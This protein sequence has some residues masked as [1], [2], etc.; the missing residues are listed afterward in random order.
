MS[1]SDIE[2]VQRENV[3]GKVL[4]SIYAVLNKNQ[5]DINQAGKQPSSLIKMRDVLCLEVRQQNSAKI[6]RDIGLTTNSILGL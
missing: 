6:N 1:K 3:E 5:N 2:K 4:S